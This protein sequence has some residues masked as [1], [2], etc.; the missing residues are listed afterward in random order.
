ML[1]LPEFTS[2]C[3][4]LL[5]LT[6][7]ALLDLTLPYLYKSFISKD[8]NYL[9]RCA[10]YLNDRI[11]IPYLFALPYFTL[12]YLIIL[13]LSL[14]CFTSLY[15]YRASP[16]LTL[17]YRTLPLTIPYPP[18]QQPRITTPLVSHRW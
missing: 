3:Q 16:Y 4:S 7:T 11:N 13:Y 10:I 1:S 8:C 15:I 5:H 18:E 2:P 6:Y 17:R 12:P 14:P 9:P